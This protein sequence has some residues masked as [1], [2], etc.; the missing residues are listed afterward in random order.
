MKTI[1]FYEVEL[2][3]NYVNEDGE[4]EGK[5]TDYSLS[6]KGYFKHTIIEAEH[7]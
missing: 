6:I 1:K 4:N 5:I 2:W 7:F 3:K